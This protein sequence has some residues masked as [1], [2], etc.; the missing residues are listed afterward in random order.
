MANIV[1]LDMGSRAFKAVS[2][3]RVKTGYV[4]TGLAYQ[5]LPYPEEDVPKEDQLVE[6]LKRF[7]KESGLR[8]RDVAIAMPGDSASLKLAEMAKMP[9]AELRKVLPFEIEQHLPITPEESVIDFQILDA[10]ASDAT[11]MNVL[12]AG[13]RLEV[14]ESL[15]KVTAAAK[16]NCAAIDVD[17]L[18]LV[19]MFEA[20]YAWE[21]DYRKVTCLLNVGNRITSVIIFDEGQYRF[22][23]PITIAGETLTR[24]IQ[25]EF[26]L[27]PEQAEDLKREQGKVVVEEAGSSFSMAM[28]DTADRTLRVYEAFSGSLNKLVTQVKLCHDYFETQYKGKTVERILLAG[29]GAKL[30]NLD[31]FLADKLSVP[32]EFADPFRQIKIPARPAVTSLIEGHGAAFGVGVGLAMRRFG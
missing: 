21:E 17:D 15:Y 29:G 6:N 25:R 28:F 19:N 11:K 22:S 30:K 1:G 26:S 5:D 9:D 16:L 20:N 2:L 27:K 24:D 4:L 23:R 8:L 31:R 14:A 13:G 18:A 7:Q 32:V 12:L 3:T 10:A